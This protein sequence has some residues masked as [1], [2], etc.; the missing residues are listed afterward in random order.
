[1]LKQ[2]RHTAK[3]SP[4]DRV[5]TRAVPVYAF[6]PFWKI[7]HL[8][9]LPEDDPNMFFYEMKMNSKLECLIS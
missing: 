5:F 4:M 9:N 1:M 7:N 8:V 2:E 3:L 6:A